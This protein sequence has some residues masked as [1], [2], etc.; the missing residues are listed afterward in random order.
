MSPRLLSPLLALASC[1]ALCG[2]AG[3]AAIPTPSGLPPTER[4]KEWIDQD[5]SVLE[6]RQAAAA[7]AASAA[8]LADGPHEWV[9]RVAA[10]RRQVRAEGDSNEWSAQLERGVRI[11]GKADI[12]RRRGEAQVEVAHARIGEARHEAARALAELWLEVINA[13]QAQARARE[14]LETAEAIVAVVQKRRRAGDASVLDLNAAEIDL[15]DVRR[16]ASQADSQ[17]D[18]AVARLRVRFPGAAPEGSSPGEPSEPMWPEERWRERILAESDPLK[19]AEG[20][21]RE[22]ELAAERARADR[23]ADPVLGVYT[24]SEAFGR[25][26]VV[27][28]SLTVPF[29]GPARGARERQALRE[30]DAARAALERQRR[31]V[32]AEV[33]EAYADAIGGLQRWQLAERSADTV[34]DS[35]RLAQRAY[36]LGETD[37][38]ALLLARRQAVDAARAAAEARSEAMRAHHRLLIDAHLIWALDQ[39]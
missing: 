18:K 11:G 4:A 10:Q 34:R 25:E 38:Q 37:L 32:L 17:R 28:L 24:A 21:L 36:A 3:A 15:A 27:G 23:V 1:V 9:A 2:P 13:T 19:I 20:R 16:Q 26:R 12:D 31:E 14:Q 8:A 33:A 6:A 35:A 39:E 22:A 7:E 29:G 30:A 5:P